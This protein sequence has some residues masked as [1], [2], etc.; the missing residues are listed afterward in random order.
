MDPLARELSDGV[1]GLSPSAARVPIWST[2]LGRRAE[3]HEFDASYW[4]SNL[5]QTVRFTDAVSGLLD[6]GVS[7]FV[8]MGPHPILLHAVEQ[9]AQST[10]REATTIACGR[11][12]EGEQAS[13]LIALGQ[14]W[15]AGYPVAWERVMPEGGR[16]VP[17]PLY[18]WQR[19]RYWAEAAGLGSAAPAARAAGLRPDAESRGWLY[20]LQ[21]EL[22]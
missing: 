12:E 20:R 17:L 14:L 7:V 1:A 8:E 6:D 13:A 5:R 22:L 4:G 21:W 16:A 9:N 18:P 19:Q 15:A 3:G 2:V 10:G 11:R